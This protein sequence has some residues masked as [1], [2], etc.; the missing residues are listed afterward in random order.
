[1][2]DVDVA[3]AAAELVGHRMG[4]DI[5]DLDG[6]RRGRSADE[7]EKADDESDDEFV[8]D[9]VVP[10]REVLGMAA[11]IRY[12]ARAM[13]TAFPSSDSP[14]AAPCLRISQRWHLLGA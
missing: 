9:V 10:A 4:R 12:L 2:E 11:I 7:R 1:V 8:H 13:S 3:E 5:F 14:W 6:V